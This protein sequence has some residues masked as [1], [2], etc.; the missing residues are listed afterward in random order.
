MAI[1]HVQFFFFFGGGGGGGRLKNI[2]QL[3]FS[4][5]GIL[6]SVVGNF[7]V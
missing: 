5:L 4:C 2:W 3:L 1:S 7:R 6:H